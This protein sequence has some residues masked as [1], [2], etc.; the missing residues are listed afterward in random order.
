MLIVGLNNLLV[1]MI[2]VSV[3]IY[4]ITLKLHF[5]KEKNALEEKNPSI[6]ELSAYLTLY[7]QK[8]YF[9]SYLLSMFLY[10][11]GLV[12]LVVFLITIIPT[13]NEILQRF[14]MYTSTLTWLNSGNLIGIT[15]LILA[16]F[17]FTLPIANKIYE[18]ALQ[19]YNLFEIR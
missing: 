8:V 1:Y 9:N 10:F 17:S 6:A 13:D 11:W 16:V 14:V 12:Y 15:S 4:Y 18:K 7:D 2:L 19:E 5:P 3:L